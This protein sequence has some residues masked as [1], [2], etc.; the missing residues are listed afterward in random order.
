MEK[1]QVVDGKA[2]RALDALR[3][4]DAAQTMVVMVAVKYQLVGWLELRKVLEKLRWVAE[5]WR[6]DISYYSKLHKCGK[7]VF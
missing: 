7:M 2:V 6:R 3:V 5:P 1:D 4:W